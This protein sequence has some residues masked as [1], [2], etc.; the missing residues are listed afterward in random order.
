MSTMS[1][2][3]ADEESGDDHSLIPIA[4]VQLL[5]GRVLHDLSGPAGALANGVE[6]AVEAD[7][8]DPAVADLLTFS[9]DSLLAR[10]RLLGFAFGRLDPSRSVSL[11]A[12]GEAARRFLKAR[13]ALRLTFP[14]ADGPAGFS[15]LLPIL[16]I[17][18]ADCLPKQG[19]IIVEH[20]PNTDQWTVIAA[21]PTLRLE[22]G[23]I[24]L[25]E[26]GATAP[27]NRSVSAYIAARLATQLGRRLSGRV[28][29][30]G[31][32]ERLIVTIGK[33]S[34]TNTET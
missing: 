16:V 17:V 32:G 30:T 15:S 23:L 7:V 18:A 9:A 29:T 2:S 4:V 6:M 22:E 33:S 20:Q 19:D 11:A 24:S 34:L 31:E 1:G 8:L 27:N 5:V 28:E 13:P 26:G 14:E 3:L 21:G 25:L 10:L 12:A